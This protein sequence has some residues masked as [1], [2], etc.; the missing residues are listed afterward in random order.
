LE[1]EGHRVIT[2]ELPGHGQD[3]APVS[4]MTLENYARRVQEAI[5][6]AGEPVVLVGHSMGGMVVTQAAEYAAP[7]IRKVVY[8][9]AFLPGNG[10]ALVDLAGSFEGADNVQP[11]LIV[12]E[13]S[14]TCTIGDD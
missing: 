6:A 5:E 3:N 4:E 13:A 14:G 12:D 9:T 10:Q 8:L 11:S 2:P 1:A 7:N